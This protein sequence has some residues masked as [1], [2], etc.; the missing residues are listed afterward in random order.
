M[1]DL[2]AKAAA[3][4]TTEMQAQ[5][6]DITAIDMGPINDALATRAQAIDVLMTQSISQAAS[7]AALAQVG[8]GMTS[9][10]IATEVADHLTGLTDIYLDDQLG[11]AM[12]HAQNTARMA[13][14][15]ELGSDVTLY[16]SELADTP[17]CC[18]NCREENGKEF[19]TTEEASADYP[20]GGSEIVWAV[21]VVGA[22]SLLCI[23][24][25]AKRARHERSS[26]VLRY[27]RY[28][29]IGSGRRLGNIDRRVHNRCR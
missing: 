22:R 27:P 10:D 14:F 5:G 21:T 23:S 9:A 11:G 15:H 4:A 25:Q 6:A 18:E 2:A 28:P 7:N 17:N 19:A 24:P 3:Q 8:P 13:V 26:R 1:Q 12:M 20:G 16:S 29:I